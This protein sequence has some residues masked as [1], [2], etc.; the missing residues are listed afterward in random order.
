M[1][2]LLAIH[3]GLFLDYILSVIMILLIP[4]PNYGLLKKSKKTLCEVWEIY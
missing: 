3:I 1:W 4:H 2:H